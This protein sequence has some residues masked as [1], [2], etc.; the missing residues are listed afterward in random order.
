MNNKIRDKG[1]AN[2]IWLKPK[3]S[4]SRARRFSAVV[5]QIRLS[6]KFSI[7]GVDQQNQG[8]LKR[9]DMKVKSPTRKSKSQKKN[10]LLLGNSHGRDIGPML[11]KHLGTEYEVTSIF[12][13]SAPLKNVV[14][15]LASLGKDL[16]VIVGGSGHSLER[17][18]HYSIEKDLNFIARRTDN[19]NVRFVN[20][21]RR[22]DKRWMNRKLRSVNLRLDRALLG[23]GMSHVGVVDTTIIGRD[24]CTVHGL[25]LN[26]RGKKKLTLIIADRLDGGH[27]LGV[28]CIP[29]ITHVRA[30][31]F[32]G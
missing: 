26:S 8:L 5:S 15:G 3:N 17:N 23:H 1:N 31:P 13:P 20:L 25:H 14:E 11:Q 27:V 16:I 28:S 12:K 6:N 10:I 2:D 4:K 9:E 19:T 18:Y 29:V 30:S 21:L 22:Y 7:L 32:L 24:Q